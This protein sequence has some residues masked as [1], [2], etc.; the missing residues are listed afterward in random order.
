V[1]GIFEEEREIDL[2]EGRLIRDRREL[3]MRKEK[4]MSQRLWRMKEAE[5]EEEE[6]IQGED[7]DDRA[8]KRMRREQEKWDRERDIRLRE[9]REWERRERDLTERQLRETGRLR[10][11]RDKGL[12]PERAPELGPDF[13]RGR[14]EDYLAM[15]E[16]RS[17]EEVE[18]ERRREDE[19]WNR[20][21]GENPM[22]SRAR[23]RRRR[24]DLQYPLETER[25]DAKLLEMEGSLLESAE[26]TLSSL[27]EL[28]DDR[29]VRVKGILREKRA[30]TSEA[31]RRGDSATRREG[32]RREERDWLRRHE[33]FKMEVD[34]CQ[35]L[36]EMVKGAK[37][38]WSTKERRSDLIRDERNR[39]GGARA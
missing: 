17:V 9:E 23:W 36:V 32:T 11:E 2:R 25:H 38:R 30:R 34:E 8:R 26:A 33:A 31:I 5:I 10:L 27:R 20:G 24:Y 4:G 14:Y 22:D 21:L 12:R 19:D 3:E 29:R 7:D 37:E 1:R 28:V 6:W 18:W 13:G 15:R 35:D 39:R 16:R